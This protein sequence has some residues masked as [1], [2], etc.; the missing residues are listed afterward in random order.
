MGTRWT[1]E[2]GVTEPPLGNGGDINVLPI[3]NT[4]VLARP[5]Y[6]GSAPVRQTAEG[7]AGTIPPARPGTVLAALADTLLPGT[8]RGARAFAATL[9][10]RRSRQRT[11]THEVDT[12]GH[13]GSRRSIDNPR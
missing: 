8:D 9:T 7:E 6:T 10:V 1:P 2:A 12:E 3:T 11:D 5:A 13:S 4:V